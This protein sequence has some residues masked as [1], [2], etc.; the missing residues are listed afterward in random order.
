MLSQKQI[1]KRVIGRWLHKRGIPVVSNLFGRYVIDNG[2]IQLKFKIHDNGMINTRRFYT[3]LA[4]IESFNGLS[5]LITAV[6][7][8]DKE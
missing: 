5:A 7:E 6:K 2:A 8:M 4:G 1:T 3:G